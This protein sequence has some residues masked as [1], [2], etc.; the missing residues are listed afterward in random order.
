MNTLDKLKTVI[1][2][3]ELAEGNLTHFQSLE[4]MCRPEFTGKVAQNL[5][6][7]HQSKAHALGR[8]SVLAEQLVQEN[9]RK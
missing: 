3:Y 6:R 8:I 2:Y 5:E 4:R 1:G 9:F 7:T